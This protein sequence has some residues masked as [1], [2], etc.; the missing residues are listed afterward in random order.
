MMKKKLI[1]LPACEKAPHILAQLTLG[2]EYEI[3]RELPVNGVVIELDDGS[4]QIIILQD[5]LQ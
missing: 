3:I 2:K 5:R 4:D 1:S